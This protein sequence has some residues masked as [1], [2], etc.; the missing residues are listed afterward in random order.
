MLVV[1]AMAMAVAPSLLS[2]LPG[3]R[4][5][6]IA[7]DFAGTMRRLRS[8]AV[9]SGTEAS[10]LLDPASR[11]YVTVPGGPRVAFPDQVEAVDVSSNTPLLKGRVA[12]FRFFP[13]G[14]ATGGTVVLHDGPR[15]AAVRVDWLTGRVRRLD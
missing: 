11:S 2:S 15:V 9:V 3:G 4:L 12:Q 8:H 13:D 5:H 14:T 7:D 6:A 1:I 10:L